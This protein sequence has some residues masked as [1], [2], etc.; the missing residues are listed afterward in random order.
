[1]R[2]VFMVTVLVAAT[3]G[4]SAGTAS[5]HEEYPVKGVIV[6][7][8][9]V[10]DCTMF[11]LTKVSDMRSWPAEDSAVVTEQQFWIALQRCGVTLVD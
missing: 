2:T 3:L 4:L 5:A 6:H 9:A 8:D 10:S 1:M 7:A 11:E